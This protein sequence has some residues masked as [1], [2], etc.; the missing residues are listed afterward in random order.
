MIATC[1]LIVF[2]DLVYFQVI[3]LIHFSKIE[4]VFSI[5]LQTLFRFIKHEFHYANHAD[6]IENLTPEFSYPVVS[7]FGDKNNNSIIYNDLI[8]ERRHIFIEEKDPDVTQLE[9][10]VN[11]TSISN[12]QNSKKRQLIVMNDNIH[13]QSLQ[14]NDLVHSLNEESQ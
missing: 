4:T 7:E 10:D 3:G 9:I 11:S 6:R 12:S 2:A 5:F 14:T 1:A 13:I 8:S